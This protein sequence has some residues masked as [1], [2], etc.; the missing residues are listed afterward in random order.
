APTASERSSFPA[1]LV[2]I[3]GGVPGD[4]WLMTA[5]WQLRAF[6]REVKAAPGLVRVISSTMPLPGELA[7]AVERDWQVPVA[8]IYGCS[9]GGMLATRRP[10]RS[11]HYVP[12]AGLE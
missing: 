12:A 4:A 2:V 9:E 5:L 10:T 1:D 8:E 6:H 11:I 7:A 3:L